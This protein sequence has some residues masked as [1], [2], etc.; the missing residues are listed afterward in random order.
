V[1]IRL[2]LQRGEPPGCEA[3]I[4]LKPGIR[5]G[6][7]I[8]PKSF[9]STRWTSPDRVSLNFFL[10]DLRFFLVR[11]EKD[12]QMLGNLP[13]EAFETAKRISVRAVKYR[14]CVTQLWQKEIPN[15]KIMN[16]KKTN[17]ALV[18]EAY[19]ADT[20]G[21]EIVQSRGDGSRMRERGTF[22]KVDYWFLKKKARFDREPIPELTQ[23]VLS[24]ATT[25]MVLRPLGSLEEFLWL[26]D[27]NRPV[28][29]AL[30]AQVQGPTT[31]ERWRDALNLVQL[32]HPLLSVS[33]ETNGNCRPHFRRETAAPIPLRVVQENNLAQRWE[34]EIE[35]ELSTPF[36]AR[37]A[38]LVRAVLLHEADQAVFILVAHHSIADGVSIAFVIRDV[39]QAL[40]RNPIGLLP[41]LPAH[42][43]ILARHKK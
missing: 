36:N 43:E 35:Q 11:T 39:L 26:I 31:V 40:S 25:P 28:H 17:L 34:S 10:R 29:F 15:K 5:G 32:R 13:G 19:N 14:Q 1:R 7:F 24:T 12:N 20:N 23:Q 21:P 38:P 30:A 18:E 33:I 41:L 6:C 9:G 3:F 37:Q 8:G 22:G 16:I 42:E 27:Q 4:C 2:S